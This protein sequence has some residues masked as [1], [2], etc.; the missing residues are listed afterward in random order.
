MYVSDPANLRDDYGTALGENFTSFYSGAGASTTLEATLPRAGPR[1]LASPPGQE[2]FFL[3]LGTSRNDPHPRGASR[4]PR[5]DPDDVDIFG[6]A[7]KQAPKA[8]G[9]GNAKAPG[10]AQLHQSPR[11]RDM[12]LLKVEYERRAF[13]DFNLS[14][15]LRRAGAE[16]SAQRF[17]CAV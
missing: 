15:S 8:A 4:P 6:C 13:H 5:H 12:E 11:E 9:E 1:K 2:P 14:E 16:V 3:R 7:V 17:F 10:L